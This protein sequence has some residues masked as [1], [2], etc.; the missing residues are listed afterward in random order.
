MGSTSLGYPTSSELK[1][2]NGVV[3]QTFEHGT[4]YW[5]AA[6]GAKVILE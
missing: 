1:N 5:D 4:I 6:T 3:Y 2:V